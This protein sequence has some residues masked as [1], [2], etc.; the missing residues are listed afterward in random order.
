MHERTTCY[1]E[2]KESAQR[3]THLEQLERYGLAMDEARRVLDRLER[4]D[5]LREA[6]SGRDA[7]LPELRALLREGHE[8]VAIEGGGTEG[9]AAILS[10]LEERLHAA[11]HASP[12]PPVREEVV[13]SEVAVP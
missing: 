9:A 3:V 5:S 1:E 6:G 11:S 13:R 12:P 10:T 2:R 8:W 4:I 7:L